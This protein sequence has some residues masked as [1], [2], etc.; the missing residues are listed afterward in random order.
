MFHSL[1]RRSIA[2]QFA[3][4]VERRPEDLLAA[5]LTGVTLE[6]V[7]RGVSN[8]LALDFVVVLL[9]ILFPVLSLAIP[10]MAG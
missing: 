6:S 7:F 10:R 9:L 8:F 3:R 5:A 4:A 2:A 1:H